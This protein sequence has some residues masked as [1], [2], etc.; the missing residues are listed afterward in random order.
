MVEV[1]QRIEEKLSYQQRCLMRPWWSNVWSHWLA[2]TFT[3]MAQCTALAYNW[4][5]RKSAM[6]LRCFLPVCAVLVLTGV[7]MWVGISELLAEGDPSLS[8]QTT[9][10]ASPKPSNSSDSPGA[11]AAVQVSKLHSMLTIYGVTC[12]AT[13]LVLVCITCICVLAIF[14]ISQASVCHRI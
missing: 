9:P 8:A 12:H 14:R 11:G 4:R 10:P 7:L 13:G 6:I 5:T 3:P 2:L 1:T